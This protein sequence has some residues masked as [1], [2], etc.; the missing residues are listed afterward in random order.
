MKRLIVL[1]LALTL[2]T[3]IV[4]PAMAS[5]PWEGPCDC[6]DLGVSCFGTP[7]ERG[8]PMCVMPNDPGVRGPNG[9]PFAPFGLPPNAGAQCLMMCI[10]GTHE[11]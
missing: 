10:T 9:P 11:D 8:H 7:H 2:L 1:L 6:P 3:S 5:P 4:A